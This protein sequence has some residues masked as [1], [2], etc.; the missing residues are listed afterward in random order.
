MPK[1]SEEQLK[2]LKSDAS[3]LLVHAAPG[4]GK[5]RV[6]IAHARM[7]AKESSKK[8]L[9]LNFSKAASLEIKSK[10]AENGYGERIE[11]RTFWYYINQLC[12]SDVRA[13]VLSVRNFVIRIFFAII[14]PFVGWQTNKFSFSSALLLSGLIFLVLACFTL[15]MQLRI[16]KTKN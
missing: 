13:T 4:A 1:P 16:I 9:V 12:D 8:I 11:S 7:K 14:G 10:I 3:K 5:T 2:I 6:L 15:I